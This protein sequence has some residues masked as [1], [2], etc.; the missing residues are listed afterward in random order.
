MYTKVKM[1]K[2]KEKKE[3]KIF[4]IESNP[5]VEEIIKTYPEILKAHPRASFEDQLRRHLLKSKVK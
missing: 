5:K 3:V 2:K 4:S 1:V